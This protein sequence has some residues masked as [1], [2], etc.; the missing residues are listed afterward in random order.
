MSVLGTEPV[1]RESHSLDLAGTAQALAEIARQLSQFSN[2]LAACVKNDS[3]EAE[4]LAASQEALARLS[5]QLENWQVQ[6]TA[7]YAQAQRAAH[8]RKAVLDALFRGG[9]ALPIELAAVTLSLPDEIRP[10]LDEMKR[11]ELI[12]IR[13]V[14][15]GQL[16]SLTARGRQEVGRR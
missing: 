3:A 5:Q 7:A 12:E 1:N 14:R 16:V 8:L 4:T 2:A 6:E 9:P 13:N 11:E 15:G 10:V